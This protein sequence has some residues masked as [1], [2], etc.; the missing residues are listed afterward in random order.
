MMRSGEV[1]DWLKD[2]PFVAL[3]YMTGILPIKKYGVH[4]A[5]NMFDEYS[6][7]APLQLAEYAGFTEREVRELCE[8]HG[9]DFSVLREWYDGYEVG[10]IVLPGE[11]E[12]LRFSIYAPRSVAKAV[13]TAEVA[14]YWGGTE[15]YEALA[16]YIRRDYDGLREKIV[17][18]MDG[19]RLP[20][21]LHTYQSW[22]GF[23]R[24]RSFR[25]QQRGAPNLLRLDG[26]AF[27]GA[28]LCRN[29]GV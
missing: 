18:L 17:L 15:T 3:A 5:L 28:D 24:G 10:G 6:M 23:P 12:A 4:S 21:N 16:R 2:Q 11:R 8:E 1:R 20:V 26:R 13:S 7:I 9:R 25:T 22:L 19:A 14:N 27:V 29:R